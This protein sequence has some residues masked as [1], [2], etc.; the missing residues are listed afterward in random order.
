MI[1][2]A[3]RHQDPGSFSSPCKNSSL[4]MTKFM[5]FRDTIYS[6][7]FTTTIPRIDK[8]SVVIIITFISNF[9]FILFMVE[10][11]NMP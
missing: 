6:S 5:S 8:I 7:Y 4:S 1:K 2:E 11:N 9:L 3:M 10:I